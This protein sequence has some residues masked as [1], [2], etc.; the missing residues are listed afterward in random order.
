MTDDGSRKTSGLPAN[1][2]EF[3]KAAGLIFAQLYAAFPSPVDIDQA[4][5]ARAFGVTDT[6]W[7]SHILASGHSLGALLGLTIGWLKNEGYTTAFGAHPSQNALLTEKGLRAM[8]AVPPGLNE[9][10]G[11]ELTKA[12]EKGR[13]PDLS[14]IGDLIGGVIGGLTKSMSN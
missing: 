10:V 8:H 1:I 13:W 3:N 11:A 9:T 6:N 4:A 7:G 14:G 5:M 2:D 12:V